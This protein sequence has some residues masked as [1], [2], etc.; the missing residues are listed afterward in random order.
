MGPAALCT[1]PKGPL[2]AS[3]RDLISVARFIA[4]LLRHPLLQMP[5]QGSVR[6]PSELF[7]QLGIFKLVDDGALWRRMPKSTRETRG[8]CTYAQRLNFT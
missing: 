8:H 7:A 3:A 1:S 6:V 5:I 2:A 4:F